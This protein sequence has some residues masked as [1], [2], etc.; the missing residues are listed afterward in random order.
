MLAAGDLEV[1]RDDEGLGRFLAPR[2]AKRVHHPVVR[3]GEDVV[4]L[5]VGSE[6]VNAGRIHQPL[7]GRLLHLFGEVIRAADREKVPRRR[8]PAVGSSIKVDVMQRS[9][10]DRLIPPV[11]ARPG[12]RR[13]GG[14]VVVAALLVL[15]LVLRRAHSSIFPFSG[16]GFSLSRRRRWKLRRENYTRTNSQIR[17]ECE[18][19]FWGLK[20]GEG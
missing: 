17:V 15:Q 1:D 6:P 7:A 18:W 13:G 10:G 12:R 9:G 3:P 8:R 16:E 4:E 19:D 2:G 5:G 14:A 11:F 20:L